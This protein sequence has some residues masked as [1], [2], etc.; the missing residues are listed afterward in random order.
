MLFTHNVEEIK[1]AAHKNGDIDGACKRAFM[2]SVSS[3]VN[4]P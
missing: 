3:S 4:E 1:G 2:V